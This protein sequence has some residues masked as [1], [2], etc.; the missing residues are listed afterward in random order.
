MNPV[1]KTNLRWTGLLAAV[2][3]YSLAD[4]A[5]GFVVR[6]KWDL[7]G[8]AAA[9]AAVGALV[10][11]WAVRHRGMPV[12]QHFCAVLAM[13][14]AIGVPATLLDNNIVGT[15]VTL[16]V[17]VLAGLVATAPPPDDDPSEWYF[18][19]KERKTPAKARLVRRAPAATARTAE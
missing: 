6:G 10:A 7:V 13:F 8:V 9:M 11:W 14:A 1:E 19:A 16:L 4:I 15:A 5:T 18:A 3:A 12:F 17:A 2:F